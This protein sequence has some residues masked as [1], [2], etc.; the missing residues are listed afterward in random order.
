MPARFDSQDRIDARFIQF[1][2]AVDDIT[3][4]GQIAV[5]DPAKARD[6][7]LQMSRS[8]RIRYDRRAWLF[9]QQHR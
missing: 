7:R 6:E 9:I 4:T 8:R 3:V 1:D 2:A 5:L